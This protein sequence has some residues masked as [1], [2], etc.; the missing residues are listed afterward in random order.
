MLAATLAQ[1]I[2]DGKDISLSL[3]KKHIHFLFFSFVMFIVRAER[4]RMLVPEINEHK[5]K[6]TENGVF[7]NE[8]EISGLYPAVYRNLFIF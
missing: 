6:N 3:Y 4:K 5:E 7:N 8:N 1:G 2:V